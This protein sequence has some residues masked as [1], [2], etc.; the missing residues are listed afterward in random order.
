VKI[1]GHWRHRGNQLKV[2]FNFLSQTNLSQSVQNLKRRLLWTRSYITKLWKDDWLICL[3]FSLSKK[4]QTTNN[5]LAAEIMQNSR[6]HVSCAQHVEVM[7]V[8]KTVVRKFEWCRYFMDAFERLVR[9][10]WR[11]LFCSWEIANRHLFFSE[12][13]DF[14]CWVTPIIITSIPMFATYRAKMEHSILFVK[15]EN[16]YF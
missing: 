6:D 1:F 7:R 12:N 5:L 8:F 11:E 4:R 14:R 9:L 15:I 13:F 2:N 16:W 10:R 3:F